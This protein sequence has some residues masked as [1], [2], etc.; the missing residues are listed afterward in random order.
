MRELFDHFYTHKEELA[1]QSKGLKKAKNTNL[2]C[3]RV[4]F[5]AS[6]LAIVAGWVMLTFYSPLLLGNK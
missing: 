3:V 6:L 5:F 4:F 2:K 1:S